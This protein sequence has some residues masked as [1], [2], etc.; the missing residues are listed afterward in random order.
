MKGLQAPGTRPPRASRLGTSRAQTSFLR[1]I[2]LIDN[3]NVCT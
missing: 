2:V 3:I 1:S